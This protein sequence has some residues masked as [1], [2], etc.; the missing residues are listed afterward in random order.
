MPHLSGK[1]LVVYGKKNENFYKTPPCLC[2]S[3][4][5]SK[6][7]ENFKI[8]GISQSLNFLYYEAVGIHAVWGVNSEINDFDILFRNKFNN[9]ISLIMAFVGTSNS[10]TIPNTTFFSTY[11]TGD[12]IFQ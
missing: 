7:F 9:R 12:S 3:S 10:G 1:D 2:C 5:Y 6:L 8:D 11:I 4:F